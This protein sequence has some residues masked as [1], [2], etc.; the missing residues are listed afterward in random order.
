[1]GLDRRRLGLKDAG[2]SGTTQNKQHEL[3]E[4]PLPAATE[5]AT[6]SP[7]LKGAVSVAFS[8]FRSSLT[9]MTT[10]WRPS[11]IYG[12]GGRKR[13]SS[14]PGLPKDFA[15]L[16]VVGAEYI[17]QRARA[18]YDAA[19]GDDVAAANIGASAR[20]AARGESFE[21]AVRH[22]PSDLGPAEM[23][24]RKSVPIAAW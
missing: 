23:R 11:I 22:L 10:N 18:E 7:I 20:D 21:L 15:G 3:G 5:N 19:R 6:K 9:G 1:M 16:R 4:S 2:L 13:A 12:A 14:E 24:S 17:V 8:G